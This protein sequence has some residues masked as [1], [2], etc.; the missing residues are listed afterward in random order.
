MGKKEKGCRGGKVLKKWKNENKRK[1]ASTFKRELG[2]PW[3][4]LIHC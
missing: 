3:E 1:S 2:K 4:I